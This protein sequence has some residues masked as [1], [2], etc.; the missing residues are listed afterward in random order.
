[1]TIIFEILAILVLIG[2]VYPAFRGLLFYSRAQKPP[3]AFFPN[4]FGLSA[5]EFSIPISGRG[6]IRGW[7]IAQPSSPNTLVLTHGFAMNKGDILK[8]TYPLAQLCNLCYFDF[9][10]SGESQGKTQVGYSETNDILHVI[11][12]L[13]EHKPQASRRIA[14]YGLS[15]GA[16]AAVRYTA[17]HPEIACLIAEAT[18]YSFWDVAR[19]WIWKRTKTPY[20]PTVYG[21]LRLKEWKLHC[22]LDDLAPK[23]TAQRVV[24]PTL[25][26]HGEKDT[27]SPVN[28]SHKIMALLA[29][30]KELWIVP[31]AGHT[32][33]A[34]E[35]GPAYT[36]RISAFIKK[37]L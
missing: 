11:N 26:I 21:Y 4:D 3:I 15:Q 36:Q 19:R 2:V 8:R 18:Y 5:E 13:K 16:G 12:F 10:G 23:N 35:A 32:S 20:F 22:R 6:T 30:P 27:I 31:S 24:V 33:C 28:N 9:L 25:L 1:M 14:L 37:H 7:F 17:N 29:G 34:R